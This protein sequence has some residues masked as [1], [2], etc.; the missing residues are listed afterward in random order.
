MTL[1]NQELNR[2]EVVSKKR[3]QCNQPEAPTKTKGAELII[4]KATHY[5]QAI[6]NRNKLKP[7]RPPKSE[8]KKLERIACCQQQRNDLPTK[9]FMKRKLPP[10][11]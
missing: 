8:T 3:K 1:V 2:G 9:I 4:T 11:L 7:H 6:R 10:H 5:V